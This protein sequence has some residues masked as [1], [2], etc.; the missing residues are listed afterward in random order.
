M[1]GITI[2]DGAVIS[3]NSHVVKDIDPYVIAGGNPAGKIKQRCSNEV[4]NL[5][6]KLSWWRLPLAQ[7]KVIY[8]DLTTKP[9]LETLTRLINDLGGDLPDAKCRFSDS[10]KSFLNK[11]GW[12]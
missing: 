2:G 6:L 4:V 8:R 7:I 1:S 12:P 9:D 3:A 11:E 10:Q 5:L